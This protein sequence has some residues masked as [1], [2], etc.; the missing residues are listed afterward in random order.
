MAIASRHLGYW[1]TLALAVFLT[2]QLSQLQFKDWLLLATIEQ[3]AV[4]T[5]I[6][7]L[8]Y[9]WFAVVRCRWNISLHD[10][11]LTATV[12]LRSTHLT[13]VELLRYSSHYVL[14]NRDGKYF[15]FGE[16]TH[17]VDSLGIQLA[18]QAPLR[19]IGLWRYLRLKYLP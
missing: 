10:C 7:V 14:I 19:D 1:A 18:H 2:Y 3:I 12:L 6:V 16:G 15:F 17:H 13:P 4:S 9:C 5:G 8:V 11:R